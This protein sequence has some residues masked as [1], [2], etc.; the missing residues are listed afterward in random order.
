MAE[1]KVP[2]DTNSDT[3][4]CG[5]PKGKAVILSLFQ[6][7]NNTECCY[8]IYLMLVESSTDV[9]TECSYDFG[10]EVYHWATGLAY[11]S[12]RVILPLGMAI[13]KLTTMYSPPVQSGS[14]HSLSQSL[15]R[16]E[17]LLNLLLQFLPSFP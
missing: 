11:N 6:L 3:K 8:Y 14:E 2:Y 5:S 12:L 10:E 15:F 17:F 9:R 7:I 4:R 13:S 1:K 16:F